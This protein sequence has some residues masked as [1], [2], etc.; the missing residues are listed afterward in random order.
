MKAR[1]GKIGGGR[2]RGD[3]IRGQ[4]GMKRKEASVKKGPQP[5]PKLGVNIRLQSHVTNSPFSSQR[6]L[7][8]LP[9]DP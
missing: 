8:Y 7:P 3:S 6:K 9:F 5:H 2:M 1:E 4:E